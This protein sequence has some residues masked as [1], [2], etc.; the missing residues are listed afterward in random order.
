VQVT[1][2]LL[3]NLELLKRFFKHL[4]TEGTG[5]LGVRQ[6]EEPLVSVGLATSHDDVVNLVAAADRNGT[7][8]I[9][10]APVV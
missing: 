8:L 1:K 2:R 10:Y 3:A 9:G 7:G 6:L 4:D 5:T